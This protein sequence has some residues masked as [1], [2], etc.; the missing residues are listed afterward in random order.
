MVITSLSDWDQIGITTRR[1]CADHVDGTIR[2]TVEFIGFRELPRTT[3]TPRYAYEHPSPA[4]QPTAAPAKPPESSKTLPRS[5]ASRSRPALIYWP[6]ANGRRAGLLFCVDG[7][8]GWRQ[9]TVSDV[10]S[11]IERL[12]RPG[13]RTGEIASRL[14]LSERTVFRRIAEMRSAS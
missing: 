1:H 14:G 12:A 4:C 10:C 11:D 8:C 13:C 5:Q 3:W 7:H 6:G 9:W 2:R